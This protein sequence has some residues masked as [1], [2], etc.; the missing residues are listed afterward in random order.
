MITMLA[1]IKQFLARFARTCYACGS[2]LPRR[3]YRAFGQEYCEWYCIPAVYRLMA[4]ERRCRAR[5]S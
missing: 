5:F 2:P 1:V 4:V 3:P